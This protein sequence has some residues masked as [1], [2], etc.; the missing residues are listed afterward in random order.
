MEGL[1]AEVAVVGVRLKPETVFSSHRSQGRGE[2][3]VKILDK[4]EA[5]VG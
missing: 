3:G 5:K 1:A 4:R 2:E